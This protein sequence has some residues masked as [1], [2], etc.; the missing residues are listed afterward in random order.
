MVVLL[1]KARRSGP[2]GA[3]SE[4]ERPKLR[5]TGKG[6]EPE[7]ANSHRNSQV[8]KSKFISPCA[9][10]HPWLHGVLLPFGPSTET[11]VLS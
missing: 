9:C 4:H 5:T 7:G 2:K 8:Q 3:S 10:A 1:F 11:K 6:A